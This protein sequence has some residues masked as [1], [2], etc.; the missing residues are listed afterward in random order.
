MLSPSVLC[1]Y[2]IT[3]VYNHFISYLSHL[4]LAVL[5][6]GLSISSDSDS[7]SFV[8][9]ASFFHT[10]GSGL[11][12]SRP[13]FETRWEQLK[14]DYFQWYTLSIGCSYFTLRAGKYWKGKFGSII[15]KPGKALTSFAE[16]KHATHIC[17]FWCW[18]V[19][20]LSNYLHTDGCPSASEIHTA[21]FH[22]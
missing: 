5:L 3:P 7:K 13:N 21:S 2:I 14:T 8:L 18:F 17:V 11:N 6:A 19:P 20:R 9:S 22:M 12:I 4:F 16:W 15:S 1:T 10:Y